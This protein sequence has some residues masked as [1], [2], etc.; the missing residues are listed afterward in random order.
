MKLSA[1]ALPFLILAA[2]LGP[3]AHGA[4]GG[5]S[6]SLNHGVHHPSD[7]CL[8]YIPR[9]IRC[10]NMKDYY[11]TSSGCSQPGVIF[12]TRRGQEVC[13][14]PSAHGVQDCI[15]QLALANTGKRAE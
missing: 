15:N 9:K 8:S 4:S 5:G 6:S 7:C 10:T 3:P 11:V 1:A 13:F 2:A 14:Y 12:T